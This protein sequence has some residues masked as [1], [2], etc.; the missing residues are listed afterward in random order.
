MDT[1]ARLALANGAALPGPSQ[2]RSLANPTFDPLQSQQQQVNQS[3]YDTPTGSRV[4]SPVA[5][6][7]R[8]RPSENGGG[9]GSARTGNTVRFA[10]TP[11][12]RASQQQG[13]PSGLSSPASTPRM[14]FKRGR[15]TPN[16]T[17]QSI[18]KAG[19]LAG[20]F[21]N[22]CTLDMRSHIPGFI[23]DISGQPCDKPRLSR[24][25]QRLY[26]SIHSHPVALDKQVHVSL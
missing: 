24:H 20:M 19:S 18:T 1:S 7:Q 12:P 9:A 25:A 26:L 3:S 14:E 8:Q 16:G 17:P 5:Q 10:D 13:G 2:W 23:Q 11:L 6:Q 21:G 22:P 4:T 15:D